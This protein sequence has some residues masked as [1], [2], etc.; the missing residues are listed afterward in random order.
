M[1]NSTQK[2]FLIY[3]LAELFIFEF[4]DFLMPFSIPFVNTIIKSFL[5]FFLFSDLLKQTEDNEDESILELRDEIRQIKIIRF[6]LSFIKI[7]KT[8]GLMLAFSAAITAFNGD[9]TNITNGLG[10]AGAFVSIA[11]D[12]PKDF[13]LEPWEGRLKKSID[14]KNRELESIKTISRLLCLSDNENSIPITNILERRN[15]I[16]LQR[17]IQRTNSQLA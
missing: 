10:F 15:A 4:L 16:P 13:L 6:L 11:S 2:S 14:K 9:E 8:I 3:V 1:F 5:L 7:M 12:I 17:I